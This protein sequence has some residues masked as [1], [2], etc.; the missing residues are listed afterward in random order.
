MRIL[1]LA[2]NTLAKDVRSEQGSTLLGTQAEE[3]LRKLQRASTGACTT[4]AWK[5][6]PTPPGTKMA[7]CEQ[8][9]LSED[10]ERARLE[11]MVL[12]TRR[13]VAAA[14]QL[15]Q[16]FLHVTEQQPSLKADPES[17][18]GV[19]DATLVVMAT[20]ASSALETIFRVRGCEGGSSC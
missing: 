5:A 11:T 2:I 14:I 15:L 6:L 16:D 8:W 19:D 18:T 9:S 12:Q 3:A 10:E 1:V 4:T 7:F 20:N 13:L 17:F